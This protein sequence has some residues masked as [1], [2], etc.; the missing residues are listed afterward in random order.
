M[1][2]EILYTILRFGISSR[3]VLFLDPYLFSGLK[4]YVVRAG[5]TKVKYVF[6][7]L[8]SKSYGYGCRMY[9]LRRNTQQKN[10]N[11]YLCSGNTQ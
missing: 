11:K 9:L 3:L 6:I 8:N 4:S 7:Y 2:Y 5:R 1:L 10:A